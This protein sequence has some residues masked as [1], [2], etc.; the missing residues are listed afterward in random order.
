MAKPLDGAAKTKLI[1]SCVGL[2]LI[3]GAGVGLGIGNDLAFN[4]YEAVISGF[5]APNGEKDSDEAGRARNMGNELAREIEREGIVL[6]QNNGT[7]PL[8]RDVT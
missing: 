3:I 8:Q 5:L 7:L 1:L 2:P 6:L 4:R